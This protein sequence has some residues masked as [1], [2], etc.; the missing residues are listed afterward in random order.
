MAQRFQSWQDGVPALTELVARSPRMPDAQIRV[1]Q[2][3]QLAKAGTAALG[4]LQSGQKP[5]AGW[6]D[7]QVQLIKDAEKPAGLVRFTFLP[8]LQKLVE[9]AA[10]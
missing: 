3:E 1:T 9:S 10:K 2:L 7:R 8:S 5:P 6:S 4:Y